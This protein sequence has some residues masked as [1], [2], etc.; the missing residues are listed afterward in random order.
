MVSQITNPFRWSKL[1]F[2]AKSVVFGGKFNGT[3]APIGHVNTDVL[4]QES[5]TRKRAC[6]VATSERPF[7]DVWLHMSSVLDWMSERLVALRTSQVFSGA[8][9]I[10]L[11]NFKLLPVRE[12]FKTLIASPREIVRWIEA[13]QCSRLLLEAVASSSIRGCP[14]FFSQNHVVT[15]C[16]VQLGLSPPQRG[17]PSLSWCMVCE[18]P[19]N[20]CLWELVF[21]GPCTWPLLGYKITWWVNT[22]GVK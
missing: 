18:G 2:L 20:N 5:C 21:L 14:S 3:Q 4:V 19:S 8:D 22:W 15:A 1:K 13:R 9:S 16:F 7:V 11:V 17:S 12:C 10:A 6:A